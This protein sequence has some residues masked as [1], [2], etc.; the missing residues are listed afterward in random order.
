MHVVSVSSGKLITMYTRDQLISAIQDAAW[1]IGFPPE[2]A[3]VQLARES[4]NFRNDV[5]YGPF[6]GGAGERGLAQFIPGT[7]SRFG[8]G[9]PYNP[10]DALAAWQYYIGY[11][12]GL[13]GEDYTRILQGYNGGEGNVQ[14]GTVSNA[15]Q[16]YAAEILQKAGSGVVIPDA[17]ADPLASGEWDWQEWATIGVIGLVAVFVIKS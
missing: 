6:V 10:D 5:V 1:G 15:A 13:F 2:I 3:V 7:W 16:R 11:L 12:R 4:A 17:A 14:R 9:D 8:S